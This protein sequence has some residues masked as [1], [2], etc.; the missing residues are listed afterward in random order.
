MLNNLISL[1]TQR[2]YSKTGSKYIYTKI[3][4]QRSSRDR[5]HTKRTSEICR[6]WTRK[7]SKN[8]LQQKILEISEIPTE[9]HKSITIPIFKNGQKTHPDNYAA[10]HNHETLYR[11]LEGKTWNTNNKQGR[12][13]TLPTK[14]IH[15]RRH[16]HYQ[17]TKRKINRV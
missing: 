14:Q 17:T 2:K 5:P 7:T 12:K 15:D 6:T 3:E 8:P 11:H 16:I 13:T 9:W 10:E 1:K 4:K